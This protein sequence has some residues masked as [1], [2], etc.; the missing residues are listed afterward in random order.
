M[1]TLL[2]TF[3]KIKKETTDVSLLEIG[4][5]CLIIGFGLSS[6]SF[7]EVKDNLKVLLEEPSKLIKIAFILT[8]FEY[9]TGIFLFG[10]LLV[11]F[12]IFAI[13]MHFND[14]GLFQ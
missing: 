2:Q 10:I 4:I 7:Y 5:S 3:A 9:V 1:D 12:G 8:I 13:A 6:I 14:F 11:L